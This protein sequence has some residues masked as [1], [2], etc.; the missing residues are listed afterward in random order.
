VPHIFLLKIKMLKNNPVKRL[1]CNICI[2]EKT[3]GGL[4]IEDTPIVEGHRLVV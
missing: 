1:L 3:I 2:H 4:K